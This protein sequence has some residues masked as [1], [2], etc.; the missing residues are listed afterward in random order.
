MVVD[1]MKKNKT[2]KTG[3]KEIYI[4]ISGGQGSPHEDNIWE[5]NV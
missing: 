3:S 5:G 1:V 2:E 4:L